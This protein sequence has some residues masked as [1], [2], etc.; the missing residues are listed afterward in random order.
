[1]A[2]ALE[3]DLLTYNATITSKRALPEAISQDS[4]RFM[5]QQVFVVGQSVFSSPKAAR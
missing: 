1:L 3:F 4:D 5:I 2:S